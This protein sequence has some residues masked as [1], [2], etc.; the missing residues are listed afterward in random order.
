MISG[1][2]AAKTCGEPA[3][4]CRKL[5]SSD[6]PPTSDSNKGAAVAR[7]EFNPP[8]LSFTTGAKRSKQRKP[9][10]NSPN[11]GS[12]PPLTPPLTSASP[13]HRFLRRVF[14]AIYKICCAFGA[15]SRSLGCSLAAFRSLFGVLR[16][17]WATV[18]AEKSLQKSSEER[19]YVIMARF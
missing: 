9:N 13:P 6:G 10:S 7:S 3:K 15:Q 14:F 5:A 16:L 2:Q 11:S 4:S 12:L 18:I 1:R 19:F 8:H 17:V